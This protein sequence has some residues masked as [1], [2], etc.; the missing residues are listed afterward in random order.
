MEKDIN[1]TKGDTIDGDEL[2]SENTK[3]ATGNVSDDTENN[4]ENGNTGESDKTED[5][6]CETEEPAV[7][8]DPIDAANEEIA[9]LKDKYLRSV[10]EFENYR[11]RTLKE[12]TEL[13]LNGGEK[14]I[15]ALLPVVDDMERA[16]ANGDKTEDP[17]VLREGM[18]LIYAKCIKILESQGV[19]KIDTDN[20][21]FDTDMHEAIA[22]VPGM[23]DDK[24]G[25]VIDCVQTGYKLNDKVIRHA[26]VAVGQ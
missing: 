17:K 8:K 12:K 10:A 19:K 22:M 25:K 13:I 7:E 11:K 3:E 15:S 20:A 5:G 26:K 1:I 23:G 21:D 16:I 6:N 18:E 4:L 14:V 2:K 24:K 9:A